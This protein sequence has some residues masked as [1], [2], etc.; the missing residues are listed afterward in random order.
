MLSYAG[1]IQLIKAVVS[2]IQTYWSQ[3]FVL[4]QK[5]VKVIQAACRT[6]LWTGK[7][8]VS[9]RALVAWEKVMKPL[10]AGGLNI[11]NL[12]LWNCAA[13]C[14]LLWC[15]C[16]AQDKLWIKWIHEYYI[17][18]QDVYEMSIPKQ[19]SWVVRKILGARDH[20][21]ALQEGQDL[22]LGSIFSVRKMY[23]AMQGPSQPVAWVKMISQNTIPAKYVFST[24]LL[25]HGRLP[26]CQ[27]LQGIGITVDDECCLCNLEKE[28]VDH[29]FFGCSYS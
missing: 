18:G 12:K 13:I 4:P 3:V 24:W 16:R 27:Y 6:F 11:T 28:T 10:P 29:L 8:N 21:K 26:T 25:L 9:R 15:L 2:G 23:I 5:V 1:R 14:K 17:K 7:T 22:L 20:F 19:S